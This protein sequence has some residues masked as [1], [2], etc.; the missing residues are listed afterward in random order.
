M[1]N[2]KIFTTRKA[3][4]KYLIEKQYEEFSQNLSITINKELFNIIEDEIPSMVLTEIDKIKLDGLKEKFWHIH[5]DLLEKEIAEYIY[6]F[7]SFYC[8][9]RKDYMIFYNIDTKK[10]GILYDNNNRKIIEALIE[11]SIFKEINFLFTLIS[12]DIKLKIYSEG[13]ITTN[14]QILFNIPESEILLII[15]KWKKEMKNHTD[16]YK[17]IFKSKIDNMLNV[18]VPL[19]DDSNKIKRTKNLE[20][21]EKQIKRFLFNETKKRKYMKWAE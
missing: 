2:E 4:K 9:K 5:S 19:D 20:N 10:L 11:L 16:R 18:I 3:V 8:E 17:R 12:N 13:K 6:F 7:T 15:K 21:Q 1:S 14:T